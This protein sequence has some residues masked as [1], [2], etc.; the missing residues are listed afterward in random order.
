MKPI[1]FDFP[2][3]SLLGQSLREHMD[4]EEG[5]MIIRS[6]PDGETYLRIENS[7]HSREI[8]L[9]SPL[10]DPNPWILNLLFLADTLRAQGAQKISLVAPYLSYMRQDKIFQPGEAL[11]SKTFA[12]LIST[13]FDALITVDPHLHRYHNLNEIYSIPT[14]D[15]K[16]TPLLSQWIHQNVENP[17]LIGPDEE[18]AQWVKEV[19]CELPY[20]VLSKVRYEDGHVNITWP[21]GVNLENK[22]PVLVDDI[23]SSGTTLVKTILHLKALTSVA[24]ICVAIHPIFAHNA[25]QDLWDAG[26]KDI[27]TTNSI[28]HPSNRMDLTPLLVEAL[29][30]ESIG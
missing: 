25:Y 10:F 28:P 11:T 30:R 4:A 1:L 5:K 22:T 19:A 23:I 14:I 9:H 24:P 17:F 7:V 20:I 26:A 3:P 18:S 27:V 21:P 8:I 16:A 12:K 2:S 6:F 15:V 13:Y 29:K